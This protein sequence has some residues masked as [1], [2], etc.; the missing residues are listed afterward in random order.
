MAE[1]VHMKLFLGMILYFALIYLMVQ[2]S[3]KKIKSWERLRLRRLSRGH[4]DHDVYKPASSKQGLELKS[5]ADQE[6]VDFLQLRS[7][8]ADQVQNWKIRRPRLYEEVLATLGIDDGLDEHDR[9]EVVSATFQTHFSLSAY[10]SWNI[11]AGV[12]DTIRVHTATWASIVVLFM[13]FA[14]VHRYVQWKMRYIVIPIAVLAFM[15]LCCMW[16]MSIQWEKTVAK[17]I[18][19]RKSMYA[20]EEGSHSLTFAPNEELKPSIHQRFNTEKMMLRILQVFIFLLANV[21]TDVVLDPDGWKKELTV[22]L[23]ECMGFLLFFIFLSIFLRRVPI[24][25]MVMACPPYVN[26][27]NLT[28]LTNTLRDHSLTVPAEVFAGS[29]GKSPRSEDGRGTVEAALALARILEEKLGPG[30]QGVRKELEHFLG[31]ATK[32]KGLGGFTSV[33]SV[34]S[35][36]Q[37]RP[38]A[39]EVF[40]EQRNQVWV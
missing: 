7:Y 28:I 26:K 22:M 6:L 1:V 34:A 29:V 40:A 31:T 9:R 19:E 30:A 24:F 38:L 17:H 12:C 39:L 36:R 5:A 18:S 35:D 32:I 27:E 2:G 8:F 13:I 20:V 11:E 25:L 16:R 3:E 21:T 15:L 23:V 33:A 4:S 37:N 10:L 14:L